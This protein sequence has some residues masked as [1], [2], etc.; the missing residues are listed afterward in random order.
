MWLGFYR[1]DTFPNIVS[2]NITIL[3]NL[4]IQEKWI[5]R[6]TRETESGLIILIT[7]SKC[8][9]W[10]VLLLKYSVSCGRKIVFSLSISLLSTM[11]LRFGHD[12]LK[13]GNMSRKDI[14]G[15]PVTSLDAVTQSIFSFPS[16]SQGR[17]FLHPEFWREDIIKQR[18]S[19][20]IINI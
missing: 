20:P 19:W 2:V 8:I 6:E 5:A 11:D 14:C 1:R 9:W 15:F 10:V 18:G 4:K 7:S 17:H 3:H 12:L 16:V 13:P